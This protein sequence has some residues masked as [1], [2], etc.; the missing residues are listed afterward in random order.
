M[1]IVVYGLVMA[2][3][4]IVLA[5]E[6]QVAEAPSKMAGTTPVAKL[7]YT[8]EYK[9]MTF[10]TL[11]DGSTVTSE[12]SEVHALDSHGRGVGTYTTST[13][14]GSKRTD[15]QTADPGS[16][17]LTFWSVPGTTG[18]VMHAPDVGEDTEC[19]RKMQAISPLH[20][21]GAAQPPITDLGTSRMLGIA[22]R[23]GKVSFMPS[24]RFG[25]EPH[26]RIN[27]VWTAIDPALDGLIV[28]TISDGG[29]A[30]KS[31][32]ELVK[33]TPGEPDPSLFQ[34]PAGRKITT[35]DGLEYSCN[36]KPVA[37]PAVLPPAP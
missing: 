12:S 21:G 28:K 1:R 5:A 11:S 6:A 31:T 9:T 33:F 34:M 22:V 25:E 37:S 2:V 16:H 23:G 26:L 32:R 20:P 15:F 8:A 10:K 18:S 36:A 19:S 4:G 29:P 35:R 30:Y 13:A 14:N 24:I 27:E 7:P 17:T 3:A